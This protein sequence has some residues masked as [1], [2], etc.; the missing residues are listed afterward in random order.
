[1]NS[2]NLTLKLLRTNI[3]TVLSTKIGNQ[4][5]C[6]L[7]LPNYSNPGDQLIWE[8]EEAIFKFLKKHIK[9][10]SSFNYFNPKMISEGDCIIL[11]GGGNFGDLY[12]SHQKFREYIIKSFPKN[13]IIIMSSTIH[14][15]NNENLKKCIK[16]YSNHSNLIIC[17]RDTKSFKI[18]KEN[19]KNNN[20]YLVTDSA[21]AIDYKPIK[22]KTFNKVLFISRNDSEKSRFEKKE[23]EFIKNLEI[24]DWSIYNQNYKISLL[25]QTCT[26]LNKLVFHLYK[27]IGLHWDQ[28]YDVNGIL[29][30]FYSKDG[31]I[32]DAIKFLSKYDLII[33]TRLHGH[34]LSSMIGI[35]NILLDN[36]YGKNKNFFNS[37]MNPNDLNAYYADSVNSVMNI[38]KVKF[39]S[40]LKR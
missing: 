20:C 21:F 11:H 17:A 10:R 18:L 2:K 26:V 19:F 33:T 23:F 1:M 22:K 35:P 25:R 27:F 8:G 29:S 6:L 24:S 7:D 36:S 14:F 34:I 5:I 39:P 4:D 30:K 37:W 9:Y 28:S 15:T 32:K 38:I 40:L 3:F 12:V 31:Q 16:L 13:K